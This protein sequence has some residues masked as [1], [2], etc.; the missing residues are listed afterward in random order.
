MSGN[1]WIAI[2]ALSGAIAVGLGAFGAHGLKERLTPEM[3]EIWKTAVLYQALHA[4]ALILFGLFRERAGARDFA[5][6][7]FLLGSVLFS[8][9][10]YGLALGG[11]KWLGAITPF[12]GVLLIVGWL[13]FAVQARWTKR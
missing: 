8:F 12:G 6:W 10:L 13:D 9:T 1:R 4:P 3:L 5:G 2:G 7:C 11:E